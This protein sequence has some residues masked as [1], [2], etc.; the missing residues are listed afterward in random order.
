M[1]EFMNL[2][3]KNVLR[4]CIKTA[5]YTLISQFQNT[6][7]LLQTMKKRKERKRGARKGKGGREMK[8]N[9]KPK[10]PAHCNSK[11]NVKC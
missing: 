5:M 1:T 11:R 4:L 7:K 9:L 2:Y 6:L 3:F 8:R 10:P